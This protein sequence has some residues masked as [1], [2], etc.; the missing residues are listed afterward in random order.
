MSPLGR[1]LREQVT[2]GRKGLGERR[3]EE[4]L[5]GRE[6]WVLPRGGH[7]EGLHRGRGEVSGRIPV[8][9]SSALC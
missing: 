9:E 1:G 8:E 5:G 2:D 6:R 4:V 7:A 3:R